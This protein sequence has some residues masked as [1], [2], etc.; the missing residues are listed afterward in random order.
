MYDS[1]IDIHEDGNG[2]GVADCGGRGHERERD[3]DHFVARANTGGEQR[4]VQS[5]G[6]G[7]QRDRMFGIDVGGELLLERADLLT[8]HELTGLEHV[9][10]GGEH[11]VLDRLVL[12]LEIDERNYTAH[13]RASSSTTR[14][15]WARD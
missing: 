15:R 12:N 4:Q 9:A 14:P 8:E 3:G 7:V 13:L 6:P 10:D 5:A 11:L 2:T 1:Q